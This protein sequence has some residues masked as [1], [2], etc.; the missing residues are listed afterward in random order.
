MTTSEIVYT[1]PSQI[2]IYSILEGCVAQISA[3]FK[4][5]QN[6]KTWSPLYFLLISQFCGLQNVVSSWKMIV[7]YCQPS[8]KAIPTPCQIYVVFLLVEITMAFENSIQHL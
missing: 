8:S 4:D 2:S 1:F 7:N 6:I 5:L 3:S